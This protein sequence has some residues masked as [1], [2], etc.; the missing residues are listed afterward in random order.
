MQ[1]TS[2]LPGRR[3]FRGMRK[4]AHA[5][6]AALLVVLSPSIAS[7]KAR[8]VG[9]DIAGPSLR[10][11]VGIK[12]PRV[13]SEFS[14]WTG[15]GVTVNGQPVDSQDGM[16][17]NWR[18]GAAP[19]RP[20]GLSEFTVTFHLEGRQGSRNRYTVLYAFDPSSPGGYIF[21]PRSAANTS[22]IVHG[23]EGN[24]FHSSDAW[25]TLIRPVVAN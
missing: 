16:F 5:A 2:S 21:L 8:T 11:P 7:A 1:R 6:V 10:S 23:E 20:A 13:V 17:I 14:I 12:D 19:E 25:E 22:L 24:W 3:I 18:K 9:I 4:A 15:P